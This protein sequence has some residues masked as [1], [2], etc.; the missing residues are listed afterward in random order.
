M[1]HPNFDSIYVKKYKHTLELVGAFYNGFDTSKDYIEQ[2]TAEDDTAFNTRKNLSSLT[3]YTREAVD[4]VRNMIFRKPT[5]FTALDGT[6][7]EYVKESGEEFLKELSVSVARD[8]YSYIL[9]EKAPYTDVQSRADELAIQP[10]MVKIDRMY[11]RNFKYVD[12]VL[13]QFTYDEGY[14]IEEG[15]AV[16]QKTQQRVYL[17]DGRVEIWRDE[18]LY[19][20][21]E[22]GLN[23]IPIV[24][25]GVEDISQ[26][27]DLAV[28]NRTHLNLQS[29]Q[30]NYVRMCANP[31]GVANMLNNDGK[32]KVGANTWLNFDAPKNEAGFGWAELSGA[33]NVVIET[34]LDRRENDMKNYI[35]AITDGAAN[36]TAKEIGLLN[37]NNESM[38][39]DYSTYLEQGFN[40]A[41]EIMADY[42][43]LTNFEAM[44][45][46]N[47]DFVS[48]G[49]TDAQ[50]REYKEL[51]VQGVISW[52]VLIDALIEGEVLK[53]MDDKDIEI[54]KEDL[55]LNVGL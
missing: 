19:Q 21:Y 22:S 12:G 48:E 31:I 26:F 35:A 42:Q 43:G 6:V 2:Y 23:Y 46:I 3:N 29:E 53:P 14:D 11:V 44:I 16:I 36:K 32:L 34:L 1:N 15:Y 25:V 24:K 10:Y 50:V 8:G 17:S 9:V 37:S 27:Y 54:M 7:L 39:N 30:R 55:V 33:N 13:T 18:K 28:L 49:M 20:T 52:R 41:L 47:R 40:R 45:L 4:T 51:Y 5:D 38:L